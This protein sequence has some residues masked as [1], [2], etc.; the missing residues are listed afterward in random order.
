[1]RTLPRVCPQVEEQM[2]PL[3]SAVSTMRTGIRL[4]PGVCADVGVEVDALGGAVRA[5]R[6]GVGPLAGVC[7]DVRVEV[8]TPVGGVRTH[9][10]RVRLLL[11]PARLQGEAPI[12]CWC[13]GVGVM[14]LVWA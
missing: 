13:V 6:T 1:M 9:G 7:A 4:L 8:V 11:T 10:A 3:N 2:R 5:V 12:S 14:V